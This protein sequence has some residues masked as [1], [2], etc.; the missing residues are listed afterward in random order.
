MASWVDRYGVATDRPGER[1]A[2]GKNLTLESAIRL[3][4][5][6]AV[7]L[8]TDLGLSVPDAHAVL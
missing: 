2:R 5:L 3:R 4:D 7:V 1:K 6:L 8:I